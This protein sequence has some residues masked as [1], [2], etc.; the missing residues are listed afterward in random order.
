[1]PPFVDDV[2][3]NL[4]FAP[5]FDFW[6]PTISFH[7]AIMLGGMLDV[8][9]S[10]PASMDANGLQARDHS[11]EEFPNISTTQNYDH[12][13]ARSQW[14]V[15]TSPNKISGVHSIEERGLATS[16]SRILP[17]LFVAVN[18]PE[19][20]GGFLGEVRTEKEFS[21]SLICIIRR[22]ELDWGNTCLL[23]P[24]SARM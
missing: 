22:P 10:N 3:A 17:G 4:D 11:Q 9:L 23:Y 21:P 12:D 16:R 20:Q 13:S 5:H 2:P 24:G 6:D 15:V 19:A 18:N 7:D 8:S 14:S 1:M